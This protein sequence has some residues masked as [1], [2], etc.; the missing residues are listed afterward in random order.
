MY[1]CFA[2]LLVFISVQAHAQDS[3]SV[4]RNWAYFSTNQAIHYEGAAGSAFGLQTVHGVRY[5]GWGVGAGIGLDL[6]RMRSYPVFLHLRGRLPVK[7]IPLYLYAEG[8]PNFI[9]PRRDEAQNRNNDR[10]EKGYYWDG[11]LQYQIPLRNK[12]FL[13]FSAGYSEKTYS[14]VFFFPSW[15]GTPDCLEV[16]SKFDYRFR[17]LALKAGFGF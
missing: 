13:V 2:L 10:T 7:R 5:K 8:G 9:W 1:K 11:G 15:C 14:E 3:L 12:T 4:K 17:R 16:N 6:Y